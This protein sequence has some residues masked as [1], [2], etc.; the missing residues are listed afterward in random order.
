M[1]EAEWLACD[2]PLAM[3]ESLTG[4]A[5]ARKL[6][7]LACATCRDHLLRSPY[8]EFAEVL[9]VAE[10]Y[11]DGEVTDRERAA[12]FATNV[13]WSL[14]E[15]DGAERHYR[16][17]V[18]FALGEYSGELGTHLR[19]RA[20]GGSV[21]ASPSSL[22]D[23]FG[24]PFRQTAFDPAWLTSTVT[25]MAA[26]IRFPLLRDADSADALGRRL[27]ERRH[28]RSLS[29]AGAACSRLL[30]RRFGVGEGRAVP[31]RHDLRRWIGHSG[32]GRGRWIT[33]KQTISRVAR[34]RLIILP[35][36]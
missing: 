21:W 15:L 29:R 3:L 10:R 13:D 8:P 6:R 20:S 30:G 11:A 24:N 16:A 27:R 9:T 23:L 2:D 36:R 26:N 28:P 33:L 18:G 19:N 32:N 22:H 31:L 25:L 34:L 5:S 7:L 1:T 12:A 4:K 14:S 35:S 17:L